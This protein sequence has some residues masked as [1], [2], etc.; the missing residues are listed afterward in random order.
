MYRLKCKITAC[1]VVLFAIVMRTSAIVDFMQD[2][3]TT[4][5]D[6][7][8]S[9]YT[10]H[11]WANDSNFQSMYES[12]DCEIGEWLSATF[13]EPK[14]INTIFILYTD[15]KH[16]SL[17]SLLGYH[18]SP[19]G[20]TAPFPELQDMW[21][22]SYDGSYEPE[23]DIASPNYDETYC[24][25]NGYDLTEYYTVSVYAGLSSIYSENTLCG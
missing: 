3:G 15:Y 25:D 4:F 21:D 6:Y 7:W 9:P 18:L 2:P 12:Q 16:L 1:L 24:A 20:Y 11:E 22:E 14:T 5:W 10:P 13:S 19:D 8:D 17:D 23:C